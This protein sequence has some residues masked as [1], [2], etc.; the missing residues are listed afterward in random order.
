MI[1]HVKPA[2]PTNSNQSTEDA[3]KYKMTCNIRL[4]S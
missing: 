3:N 4:K 1:L 2:I